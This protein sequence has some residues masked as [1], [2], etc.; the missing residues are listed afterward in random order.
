M[1]TSF[2]FSFLTHLQH[3]GDLFYIELLQHP[4]V[5]VHLLNIVIVGCHI[6]CLAAGA[7]VGGMH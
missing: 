2:L 1:K 4:I 7:G 3:V 5:D 6:T